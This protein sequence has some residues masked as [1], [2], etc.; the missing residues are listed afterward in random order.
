MI[1]VYDKLDQSKLKWLKFL[2]TPLDSCFTPGP[3][4][5]NSQT[6]SRMSPTPTNVVQ[7]LLYH[8][9][10]KGSRPHRHDLQRET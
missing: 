1:E 4:K 9:G 5:H 3:L 6:I 2:N 10:T 7:G 8:P